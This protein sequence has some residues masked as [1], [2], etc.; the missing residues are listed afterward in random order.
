MQEM[1][2]DRPDRTEGPFTVDAGHLQ[3]ETDLV[4]LTRAHEQNGEIKQQ[5]I[6]NN[7]Q[8]RLG[9]LS[10]L[11]IEAEVTSFEQDSVIHG[12][13]SDRK[14]GVGDLNF[15]VKYNFFGNREGDYALG[16]IPFLTVPTASGGIGDGAAEGGFIL[17][18]NWKVPHGFEIAMMLQWSRMKNES[19]DALHSEFVSSLAVA[20]ELLRKLEGYVEI[21]NQVTKEK[22]QGPETTFDAGLVYGINRDLQ[23]DLGCNFGLSQAAA[24]IN[25]FLGLSYRM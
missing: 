12:D 5:L 22:G 6:M 18:F 8:A 20:H 15:R 2:T 13:P 11:D 19:D 14:R 25:P 1:I 4:A 9:L 16:A 21:Y 3:L 24:A 10:D 17:P 7:V 23:L